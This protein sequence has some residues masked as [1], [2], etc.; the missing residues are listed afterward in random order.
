MEKQLPGLD[1]VTVLRS[2]SEAAKPSWSRWL[3]RSRFCGVRS[4]SR[5]GKALSNFC[6]LGWH[7]GAREQDCHYFNSPSSLSLNVQS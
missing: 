2:A 4:R 1:S 5:H 3:K 7:K 6:H